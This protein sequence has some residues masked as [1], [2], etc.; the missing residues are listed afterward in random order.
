MLRNRGTRNGVQVLSSASVDEMLRAQTVGVPV[1]ETP[2]PH[3]AP[4]GIGAWVER[5]DAQGRTLLAEAAGAF[6]FI[7]WV[8][9]AHDASGVFLVRNSND[10]TFPYVER[11]W[12]A[13]DDAL[14]PDGLACVGTPSPVC[15]PAS[16]LGANVAARTGEA[17]FAFVASRASANGIGGLFLGD[18]LPAGAVVADLSVFVGPVP[19][20]LGVFLADPAGRARLPT[21]L[22]GV[23]AGT[24]VGLQ[25]FWLADPCAALGLSASHGVALDVLP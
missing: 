16:W 24:A 11:T 14:L 7:G 4:Y 25:A 12:A 21:P 6:G 2:H 3:G 8:D 19:V 15:T 17:E 18:V 20:L 23:P 13:C 22:V 1:L 10:Q 9:R 5:R